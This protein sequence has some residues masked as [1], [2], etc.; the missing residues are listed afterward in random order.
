MGSLDSLTQPSLSRGPAPGDHRRPDRW[1]GS[2]H[3]A[4]VGTTS[5]ASSSCPTIEQPSNDSLLAQARATHRLPRPEK[6]AG[7]TS[8]PLAHSRLQGRSAHPQPVP[9]VS[10]A[11]VIE[12]SIA[13]PAIQ[14]EPRVSLKADGESP[15]PS[16]RFASPQVRPGFRQ[17]CDAL[18]VVRHGEDVER[19]QRAEPVAE[20][21][22]RGQVTGERR[23]VAGDVRDDPRGLSH[24]R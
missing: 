10:A 15:T 6:P 7:L 4:R 14:S 24:E 5:I 22:Q 12:A 2:R 11:G 17:Q 20:P 9:T 1:G 13:E 21:L 18:D 16:A 19:P 8:V 3:R 23:R